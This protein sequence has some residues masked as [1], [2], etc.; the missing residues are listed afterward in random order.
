[1]N[2]A[3]KDLLR[4]K[5]LVENNPWFSGIDASFKEAVVRPRF[6]KYKQV[7]DK[8]SYHF[9]NM[10]TGESSPKKAAEELEQDLKKLLKKLKL[11]M[12]SRKKI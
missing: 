1:M 6:P 5:G 11:R 7:S 2:P 3:R 4:D 9:T 10:I 12:A 8:I